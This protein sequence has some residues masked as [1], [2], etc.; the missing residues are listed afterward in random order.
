MELGVASVRLPG[1]TRH[2]KGCGKVVW[3]VRMKGDANKRFQLTCAPGD[4]KFE[5]EYRLARIGVVP[6]IRRNEDLRRLGRTGD[7]RDK[8]EAMVK[9][10]QH[11]AK[12]KGLS[13][14]ITSDEI[15]EMIESQSARCAV[16]RISFDLSA[17]VGA[18]RPFAPSLD[19]LDCTKGYEKDNIRIT[20]AIVNTAISD[21]GDEVF[22]EMCKAVARQA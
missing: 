2:V 3:R 11:R 7:L 9:G 20:C 1:L 6:D 16:S 5:R 22:V 4:P 15:L 12:R 14:T 17:T 10:A 21:W 18:R 19:R 8:I 13:C